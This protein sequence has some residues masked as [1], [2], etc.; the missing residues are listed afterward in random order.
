MTQDISGQSRRSAFSVW[1]N[2]F[3]PSI[4]DQG[5][6]VLL[7]ALAVACGW[8][9][10]CGQVL[11]LPVAMLFPA[12]WACS[13]SRMAAAFVSAGY[14][15]AASRGLPQGVA[16]F[17]AAD[18]WPG[19]LLWLAASLAFVTVHAVVWANQS[20]R[21]TE[22]GRLGWRQPRRWPPLRYLLAMVLMALPPFGIVGWAQPL[23][24]A[25]VVFPGWGWWGLTAA[26]AG[27]LAMTTKYWPAAAIGLGGF[28][29]W[30]AATWTAPALPD[31]W[32]GVDLEM[33]QMLGRDASLDHHRGMIATAWISASKGL[34][35]VVLPESA[36]G[37]WTPTVEHIWRDGLRGSGLVVIAGTA[38]VDRQGYDNLMVVISADEAS[39]LYRERMPVPVSMWQP[40]SRW[41]GQSGG[42]HAH[43]FTN[44]VVEIDG[45]KIAPLICYEQLIVWP[46]LQSMLHTPDVIVAASNGW[47]TKGTPIVEIQRAS[48]IA[49]GRLFGL[50]VVMAFNT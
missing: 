14:F 50:P 21:L 25:G 33:G 10:W 45:E 1:Q 18:L 38:L 19:L 26:T 12:L 15:L 22:E 41:T 29:L 8:I 46:I 28:W 9:G 2:R 23:T 11:A 37:F 30:S 17:Y 24:A 4:R 49:W 35:F 32:T 47:W 39:I 36:L 20:D 7:I 13:P 27:L 31:R 48:I 34:R 3:S 16:N 6:S 43:F 44:P 42:A 40:W 5:R